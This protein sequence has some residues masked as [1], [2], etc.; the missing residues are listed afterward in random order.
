[1]K[2][3][4]RHLTSVLAWAIMAYVCSTSH[5]D[6]HAQAQGQLVLKVATSIHPES[7]WGR[8]LQRFVEHVQ[9]GSRQRIRVR[10]Y[11]EGVLGSDSDQVARV[12]AGN[13]Q[14]YAG[15]IEALYPHV[16]ALR[17]LETPGL[18]NSTRHANARLQRSQGR[19]DEALQAVGLR[20][21]QWQHHGFRSWFSTQDAARQTAATPVEAFTR[22][23]QLRTERVTL[24]RH[25]LAAGL[26]VYS[27]RWFDGLPATT[28][29]FLARL[30][31]ELSAPLATDIDALETR[32]LDALKQRGA[33][34]D[35]PTAAETRSSATQLRR[36]TE[37][38]VKTMD[39]PGRALYRQ[40]DTQ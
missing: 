4:T 33:N 17:A 6:R 34:V 37:Q 5:S 1:M 26:L 20:F 15:P 35:E 39:E 25:V 21:G 32:L 40:L 38:Y 23:L 27:Q 2:F 8:V 12:I 9:R 19:I 18:F 7:P 29:T 28:Q 30:P 22:G 31:A 14:A 3:T 36:D 16:S 11:Y 10:V 13:L 24:T